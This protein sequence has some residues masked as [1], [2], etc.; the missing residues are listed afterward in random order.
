MN[1]IVDGNWLLHSSMG[2]DLKELSLKMDGEWILKMKLKDS[3]S[4]HLAE[5]VGKFDFMNNLPILYLVKDSHSWRKDLNI[6]ESLVQMDIKY[7]GQRNHSKDCDF[8]KIAAIFDEWFAEAKSGA[9]LVSQNNLE[10]DDCILML[11]NKFK[12]AKQNTV[13][14]SSDADL[15]QLCYTGDFWFIAAL[16]PFDGIVY[17]E[18]EIKHAAA[19]FNPLFMF[20]SHFEKSK[21]VTRDKIIVNKILFGDVSDNIQSIGTVLRNG[22]KFNVTEKRLLAVLPEKIKTYDKLSEMKSTIANA[23][24]TIVPEL[25]VEEILNR[26]AYNEKLVVLDESYLP[27]GEAKIIRENIGG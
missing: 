7:K 14:V 6:P 8:V 13:I 4:S 25:S 12:A 19:L 5:I 21:I 15:T 27:Q 20:V 11:V 24:H 26:L 22:K 1:I 17:A 18:Q 10:G 3:L 16:S 23:V 2:K 9:C